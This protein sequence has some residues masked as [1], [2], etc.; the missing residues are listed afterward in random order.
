[1]Y[2]KPA[3]SVHVPKTDKI[4]TY[5]YLKPAKSV[6]DVPKTDKIGT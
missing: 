1:M 2:L 4:G 6:H 5:M 3:K